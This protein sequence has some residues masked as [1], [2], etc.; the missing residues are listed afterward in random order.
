[1]SESVKIN[2]AKVV[3]A[4]LLLV[5]QR[6]QFKRNKAV[7]MRAGKLVEKNAKKRV[8][9]VTGFLRSQIFTD[10]Q[11]DHVEI[12]PSDMAWYGVDEEMGNS[13]R[14]PHPYL[15]PAMNEERGNVM[16]EITNGL[17]KVIGK[18]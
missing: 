2:G 6:M 18:T 10:W 5:G 3:I 15:R 11:G 9:V 8:H 1:M 4:N 7:Y 12:R 16:K 13:R 14:P 17:K